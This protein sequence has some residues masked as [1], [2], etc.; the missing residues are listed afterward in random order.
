MTAK[1]KRGKPGRV[2]P[3]GTVVVVRKRKPKCKTD[4][5]LFDDADLAALC[6]HIAIGKSLRSWTKK[7]GFD[8]STVL[9]WLRADPE[10]RLKAYREARLLQTDVQMDTLID[11]AD[12][13]VPSDEHGRMDSAAVNDKRLRIDTR[14]WIASKMHPA[15]Y[16]DKVGIDAS[17][18]ANLA[19]L[20]PDQILAR[21]A[22]IFAANGLKVV[23]DTPESP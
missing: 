11:L 1:K 22:A 15:V 4:K 3:S 12:E 16:G 21:I 10:G 7:A 20:P 17:V 2:T 9:R 8:H 19:D 5:R 14:K 6:D 23:A 13:P 18:T